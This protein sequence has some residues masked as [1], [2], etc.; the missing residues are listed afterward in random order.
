MPMPYSTQHLL[1]RE[2]T[3]LNSTLSCGCFSNMNCTKPSSRC[4]VSHIT[5]GKILMSQGEG[6][7]KTLSNMSITTS[8]HYLNAIEGSGLDKI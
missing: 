1:I 6:A 2:C 7:Y 4:S 5:I 8:T 3:L